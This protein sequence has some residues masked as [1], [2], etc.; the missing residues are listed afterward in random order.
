[1]SLLEAL[2]PERL[3]FLNEL[4]PS[5][6]VAELIGAVVATSRAHNADYQR[7]VHR[8]W[9]RHTTFPL[10]TVGQF[11]AYYATQIIDRYVP[12]DTPAAELDYAKRLLRLF[13][14]YSKH[15]T[16]PRSGD[17]F[18]R[19]SVSSRLPIE[20]AAALAVSE[21]PY[22]AVAESLKEEY[23]TWVGRLFKTPLD[24]RFATTQWRTTINC[25][26]ACFLFSLAFECL[27]SDTQH[28][29][30]LEHELAYAGAGQ[31][32]TVVLIG[33][34][35]CVCWCGTVWR[36]TEGGE[37]P[38]FSLLILWIRL[39]ALAGQDGVGVLLM[40]FSQPAAV[41]SRDPI[42]GFLQESIKVGAEDPA[43]VRA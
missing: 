29:V 41:G 33:G 12:T 10:E 9:Q 1:M 34:M 2:P 6:E 25:V 31:I 19:C 24:E 37:Y 22:T 4:A 20:R 30:I 39:S 8:V 38:L 36:P 28:R 16:L 11:R 17:T 27:V 14:V 5:P 43:A 21:A 35:P 15:T 7:D 26:D 32:P 42:Y 23:N 40:C 3:L 13:A 18:V